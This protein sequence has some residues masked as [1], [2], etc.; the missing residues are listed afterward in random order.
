MK[1]YHN[2]DIILDEA[3]SLAI[4]INKC[5]SENPFIKPLQFTE[6]VNQILET[7]EYEIYNRNA[8]EVY[9]EKSETRFTFDNER[10]EPS[11][12]WI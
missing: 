3:I 4:T 8:L 10:V 6:M 9:L 11:A 1:N 12:S 7:P 5:V 2:W